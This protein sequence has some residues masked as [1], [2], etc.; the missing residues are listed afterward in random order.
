MG[1]RDR[2][3][4]TTGAGRQ[5]GGAG[6]RLVWTNALPL[7]TSAAAIAVMAYV[8]QVV[9][10]H[11]IDVVEARRLLMR[12]DLATHLGQGWV[13]YHLLATGRIPELLWDLWLQGYW[14]PVLS[15]YQVPFFLLLGGRLSAGLW[16]GLAAFGLTGLAG[17]V[18]LWRQWREASVLPAAIFLALLVSS[19]ALLAY[20]SVPMTEMLGAFVQLLVLLA[21]VRYRERGSPDA[22][23]RFAILLTL[24]FFTKYN[25]FLLLA[26]PLAILEWLERTADSPVRERLTALVRW[27]GRGLATPTGA[28][29][30]LYVAALL[31]LSRTGGFDVRVLGQ[32]VAVRTIGNS[33]Y[34]VLALLLAR[35]WYRHRRRRIDWARL[36]AADPLVRPLLLWL[37]LPIIAWLASPYPNHMRDFYNL[38][39]NRPLGAPTV[40]AGIATYVDALRASYFYSPWIL[41]GVAGAFAIAAARY[42]REPP[43]MRLLIIAIPLQAAVIAA[44]QTRFPRFLLLTVVL[45]CLAAA[46]AAGR[47][48]PLTRAGRAVA[49]LLSCVA[50]AAGLVAARHAVSQYRFTVIAFENYTDSEAIRSAVDTM[51]GTLDQAERLAV[52]GQG[53]ELSPA[54]FRWEL[55]PPSG[56]DCFPFAVGGAQGMDQSLATRVLLLVPIT[57]GDSALD[58]TSFYLAQRDAVLA[59]AERGELRVRRE[60][61]VPDRNV[62]LRLYDRTSSSAPTAPCR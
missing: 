20:G 35:L 33:G 14:P 38:V 43:L 54:L 60:V 44:H 53:N 47:W 42:R 46:S 1:D 4:G 12:W 56:L 13:D 28:L 26:A 6:S 59:R 31:V 19:P 39:F 57:P 41:A 24:L 11:T 34:V 22:A 21:F 18:L 25:Y 15:L 52:V 50:V 40:E 51:R 2:E 16:A 32:R 8:A 5:R 49:A 17:C 29:L 62:V 55:G 61:P 58:L 23:R 10:R 3:G 45:L 37:V 9:A 48:V 7:M 27:T 36:V 30:A